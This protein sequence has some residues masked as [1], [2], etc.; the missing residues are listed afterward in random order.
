MH[1]AWSRRPPRRSPSKASLHGSNDRGGFPA[2]DS[3]RSMC[4][5]GGVA[6]VHGMPASSLPSAQRRHGRF[7][8]PEKS[9]KPV[10]SESSARSRWNA[11]GDLEAPPTRCHQR[12]AARRVGLHDA[13]VRG[14]PKKNSPSAWACGEGAFL[15]AD[16]VLLTSSAQART[17]SPLGRP[18]ASPDAWP[19]SQQAF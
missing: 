4:R 10:S 7:A 11:L 5:A 13:T 3:L 12:A 8:C 16:R 1:R 9:K 18:V 14:A 19:S 17:A 2:I 15:T 6:A